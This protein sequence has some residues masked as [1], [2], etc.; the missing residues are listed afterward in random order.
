LNT[1]AKWRENYLRLLHNG[2]ATKTTTYTTEEYNAITVTDVMN[3]LNN[4]KNRKASGIDNMPVELWKY[5]GKALY[6]R[7]V[8]LFNDIW[9]QGKIPRVWK[10]SLLIPIDKKGD[11]RVCSNYG[12]ISLLATASKIYAAI[13]KDK[14]KIIAEEKFEEGQFGFRK[15]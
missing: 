5:G 8:Q 15:D 11:K 6:I 12:G 7:L 9:A 2:N 1:G 10:T 14:L 3:V 13:L 4:M